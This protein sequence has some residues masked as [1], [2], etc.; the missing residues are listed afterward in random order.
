MPMSPIFDRNKI[1][2][3]IAFLSGPDYGSLKKNFSR[4][5]SPGMLTSTDISQ[6][7]RNGRYNKLF[8]LTTPHVKDSAI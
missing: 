2:E 3:E 7:K 4:R 1:Q 5:N 8:K 6:V